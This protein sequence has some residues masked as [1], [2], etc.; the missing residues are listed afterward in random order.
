MKTPCV[1]AL[2]ACT[3]LLPMAAFAQAPAAAPPAPRPPARAPAT[4]VAVEMAQTA[5]RTCLA[6]GFKVGASVVD[7]DGAV[8]V[9]LVGDGGVSLLGD[10]AT[11]KAAASAIFKDTTTHIAQQ[12]KTDEALAARIKAEPNRFFTFAGGVPLVV[13]GEVIGALGVGGAPDSLQDELCAMAAIAAVQSR[14]K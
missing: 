12:M 2:L 4:D 14:L 3:T 7:A 1:L 9:L 11:R 5:I 10:I 8:R 13:G 6:K